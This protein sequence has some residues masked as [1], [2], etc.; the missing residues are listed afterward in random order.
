MIRLK[1]ELRLLSLR[2]LRQCRPESGAGSFGMQ[3][4]TRRGP[5]RDKTS[6]DP[7]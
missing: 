4:Q 5:S 2:C 3:D 6:C 1:E 7:L